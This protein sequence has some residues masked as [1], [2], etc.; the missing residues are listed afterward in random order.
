[1]KYISSKFKHYFNRVYRK[2]FEVNPDFQEWL[3]NL[4]NIR[5]KE[6]AFLYYIQFQYSLVVIYDFL[7]AIPSLF[8]FI[9]R[10]SILCQCDLILVLWFI[11]VNIAK[12]IETIFKL[13]ILY[14]TVKTMKHIQNY[15]VFNQRLFSIVKSNDFVYNSKTET[16][17]FSSYVLYYAL[18]QRIVSYQGVT[19]FYFVVHWLFLSY[20]FRSIVSSIN[21]LLSLNS[22]KENNNRNSLSFQNKIK[23]VTLNKNNMDT[24]IPFDDDNE[25]EACCICLYSYVEGEFINIM[26]CRN[27][28]VFHKLCIDRWL[29]NYS[30]ICP[31]CRKNVR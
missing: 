24:Y 7:I 1:M 16:I 10:F 2:V 23:S 11:F 29:S 9:I 31:I 13:L 3:G 27:Q 28:H 15:E 6:E 20:C 25:K 4:N 5:D 26:P 17:I 19:Q 22:F 18:L 30:Q 14:E 12:L 8:Y 21:Y